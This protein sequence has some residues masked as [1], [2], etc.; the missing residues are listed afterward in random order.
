VDHAAE[1]KLAPLSKQLTQTR[2][3]ASIPPSQRK[4]RACF[5]G[6]GFPAFLSDV[7]VSFAARRS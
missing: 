5:F 2:R 7:V 4:I 3:S 1:R 6:P